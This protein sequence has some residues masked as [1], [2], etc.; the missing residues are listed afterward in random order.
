MWSFMLYFEQKD[1]I[2]WFDY[3]FIQKMD[4]QFLVGGVESI[5]FLLYVVLRLG[6]NYLVSPCI[7]SWLLLH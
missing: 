5:G 4:L 7:Y 1:I 3:S 2:R 6:N